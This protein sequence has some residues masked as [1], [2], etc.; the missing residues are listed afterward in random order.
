MVCP[1]C[2]TPPYCCAAYTV[3]Q[4]TAASGAANDIVLIGVKE[5]MSEITAKFKAKRIRRSLQVL[6]E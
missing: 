6:N 1:V 5:K 4:A 3:I 2:I